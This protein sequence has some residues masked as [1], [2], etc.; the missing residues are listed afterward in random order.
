MLGMGQKTHQQCW[1]A[2]YQMLFWSKGL[3][4]DSVRTKLEKVIDLAD[5]MAHGLPDTEFRQC[6]SALSMRA[7]AGKAFNQDH[8]KRRFFDLGLSD[9]AEA[10][11]ALLESGPLWVSRKNEAGTYHIT[12][13]KGY[14]KSSDTFIFNNPYPGPRDA[15]EQ[16]MK[17]EIYARGITYAMGSVQQ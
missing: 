4:I 15:L 16:R 13:L 12:V 11:Y 5:S 9:G 10:L 6:A 1:F 17:S 14:D 7:W 3:N 2:S 8:K